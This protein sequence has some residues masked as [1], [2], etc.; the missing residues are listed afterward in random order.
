[1]VDK[2]IGHTVLAVFSGPDHLERALASCLAA[3]ERVAALE[4]AQGPESAFAHGLAVGVD[5]GTLASGC[6]GSRGVGRFD[7]AVLGDAVCTAAQLQAAAGKNE[8]LVSDTLLRRLDPSYQ[9][10]P[11]G[12]RAVEGTQ[13]KN[14]Q[15]HRLLGKTAAV[16]PSLRVNGVERRIAHSSE[17]TARQ[18]PAKP[19]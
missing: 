14:V 6:L 15:V 10:E 7:H 19:A 16:P 4:K 1:M 2:F 3:R 5:A 11:L 18:E 8:I 12:T 17:S 9:L 13:R